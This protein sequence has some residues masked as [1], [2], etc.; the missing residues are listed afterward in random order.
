MADV[1]DVGSMLANQFE[2]KRQ[3]QWI[4]NIDGLDAYTIVSAARPKGAFG[5]PVEMDYINTKWFLAGKWKW[6]PMEI[7]LRD[8][9]APSA[10]QK[11]MDWVRLCYEHETGRAGYAAFYKKEIRLKLLDGPGAV[12]EEWKI[13]GAWLQNVDGG[14]LDWKVD[15]PVEITCTLVF[16]NA[17]L[18]Y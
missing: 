2:P 8:P 1:L 16:D 7:K 4:L 5:G 12:V 9:I 6:D 11:V 18:L 10:M 15:D 14:P 17:T 3:Y 13:S